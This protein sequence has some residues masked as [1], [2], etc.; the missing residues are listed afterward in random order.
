MGHY[1]QYVQDKQNILEMSEAQQFIE[2]L[3]QHMVGWGVSR[4][5]G[6]VWAYLLLQSQPVSLQQITHELG[7]AKS[8]ASVATRQLVGF[9]LA[10]VI[11]QRGSKRLLYE[12][13]YD[14]A[15]VLGARNAQTLD[16]LQR[17]R[18][19]ARLVPAGPQRDRLEDMAS[20]LQ[21][22]VDAM[23]ELVRQIRERRRA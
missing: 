5:T 16:F 21:D 14:L 20:V 6:R 3:G 19:A 12:A 11:G 13:L 4:T 9:G 22:F 1:D 17:L 2:D 18:Q 15:S 7:V 10:R 23:P 8:G